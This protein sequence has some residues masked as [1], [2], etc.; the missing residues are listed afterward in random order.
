MTAMN[1]QIISRLA[2]ELGLRLQ[3]IERT[4]ALLDAG[5]TIP[6]IT[7]YRKEVTGGL[8][9]EQLR[10]LADRLGYLRN[11]EARRAEVRAALEQGAHLTPELDQALAAAQTLQT[12]EDLYLPFRPKKRT[13][14]QIARERGLQ[15][16][17]DQLFARP[18]NHTP[19]QLAEPFVG[20]EVPDV[21]AAL[22]GARDIIAEQ[23]AET[24]TVRQALREAT[25]R[26]G[27]LQVSRRAD[28][29]DAKGTYRQYYDYRE[30]LASLPPHRILAINRGEREGVL[31]VDLEAN[32][33]AFIS[34]LQ[35]RHGPGAGPIDA[36][37]QAAV[38][39]G[40]KRLLA[41]AVE[42]DLRAELT[43]RAEGHAL[44]IFAANLRRLLLQPPLRGRTVLGIDPGYRTGCKLAVVDA[45]GRP[46]A[47]GLLY[48]H[49]AERA[50]ET[51]T[52]LCRQ[53]TV[54]VIAI[55]NGTASRETEQLVAE[56]IRLL[57]QS[58]NGHP[59][60]QYTLVSEAGA[61][62]YSASETAKAEFPSLDA[63]ERGTISIARR[64]QDPLAELVKIEPKA[65]GVG[66]YQHDVDQKALTGHLGDVVESSVNYVGV[67]LN[68]ASAA[69][70]TYVAGMTTKTARAVVEHRNTH[71]PFNNRRDL[72]KVKGLGPRAFE[73]AAGFL[74]IPDA[75]DLLDRTAVHPE[76][77]AAARTLI[78]RFDPTG[79]QRLPEVAERIKAALSGGETTL[80][81]LATSLG[82]GEP[83]LADIIEELARPGRDRARAC[84]RRCCGLMC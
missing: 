74:R 40:Y 70:L 48:L 29:E 24:A 19:Q 68:T 14:A 8:D 26:T 67:D 56:T 58:G 83:T 76:S 66:M 80:A 9:E 21:A 10:R 79:K 39:D 30:P 41:P 72:L 38:A 75:T 57:E 32:H 71:G 81:E 37:I 51:L 59:P 35:R 34:S 69:L 23:M 6:F 31:K 17:A 27:A 63:T 11:L 52:N 64:L 7:R 65:L 55:G 4:V 78:G 5:D 62:V 73:Q 28:V 42:R 84:R 36:E 33:A 1:D 82:I 54:Q 25:R 46:L 60:L 77:Y 18:H 53:W 44:T 12:I 3:Q 13:R 61:S 45:T 49:Q 20:P 22:A 47:S 50:K 43:E 15:G 2:D 16:L